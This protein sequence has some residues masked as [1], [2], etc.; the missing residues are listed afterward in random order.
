M[1]WRDR[2]RRLVG[3]IMIAFDLV[4]LAAACVGEVSAEGAG[5]PADGWGLATSPDFQ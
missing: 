2:R 5:T 3:R 4:A 1:L